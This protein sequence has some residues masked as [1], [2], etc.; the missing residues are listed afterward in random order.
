M[1]PTISFSFLHKSHT[2]LPSFLVFFQLIKFQ[3]FLISKCFVFMISF[4]KQISI[5]VCRFY[6]WYF[7]ILCQLCQIHLSLWNFFY[8]FLFFHVFGRVF[9]LG[10]CNV[11]FFHF[12][13]KVSFKTVSG[14]SKAVTPEM[15]ARWNEAILPTLL[16]NYGLDNKHR[17][18]FW[19]VLPMFTKKILSIE[20]RERFRW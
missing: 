1:C 8:C 6:N 17:R 5:K 9:F 11:F 10:W 20:N 16:S 2:Y 4:H 7:F 13:N 15:V 3:Q 18:Q 14:E 12:R 19:V